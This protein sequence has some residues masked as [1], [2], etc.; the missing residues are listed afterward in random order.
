MVASAWTSNLVD[1]GACDQIVALAFADEVHTTVESVHEAPAVSGQWIV[2]G[3]LPAMVT[4]VWVVRLPIGATT[5]RIFTMA[6]VKIDRKSTRLNSSHVA[7]SYAVFCLKKKT[8][9]Y[10]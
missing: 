5:A 6:S 9:N 8:N 3:G 7:I 10:T 4:V 1:N 2:W